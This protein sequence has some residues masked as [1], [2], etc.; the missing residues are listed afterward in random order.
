MLKIKNGFKKVKNSRKTDFFVTFIATL[1]FA[2]FGASIVGIFKFL[3]LQSE[4]SNVY[5][6]IA[7]ALICFPLI[8]AFLLS[9]G[10][11]VYSVVA[12]VVASKLSKK[13]K[14]KNG[15]LVRFLNNSAKD[16]LGMPVII[17]AEVGVVM[18]LF[19]SIACS[20]LMIG[21]LGIQ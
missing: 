5:E 20:I 9:L 6:T 15:K 21:S 17:F 2:V 11:S 18:P 12:S 3:F 16:L 10:V 4:V 7:I 19:M 14:Y 13:E 1:I 8:A